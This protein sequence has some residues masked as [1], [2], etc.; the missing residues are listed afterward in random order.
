MLC[1]TFLIFALFQEKAVL[2]SQN[3]RRIAAEHFESFH[4]GKEFLSFSS[5]S[6]P[7]SQAENH[8]GCYPFY[9]GRNWAEAEIDSI[10]CH[11]RH[12]E[13]TGW[14]LCNS[15]HNI[16]LAISG[17]TTPKQDWIRKACSQGL[18][19]PPSLHFHNWERRSRGRSAVVCNLDCR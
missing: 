17:R 12:S 1:C 8:S 4:L 14:L 5:L 3:S 15:P 2:A 16:Y 9:R 11:L 19:A 7:N 10:V 18:L 13:R 6:F